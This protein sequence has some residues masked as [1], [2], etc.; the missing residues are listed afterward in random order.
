MEML[1]RQEANLGRRIGERQVGHE[2]ETNAL[3]HRCRW[4]R[5]SRIASSITRTLSTMRDDRAN[6]F[7]WHAPRRKC[8]RDFVSGWTRSRTRRDVVAS[9][10]FIYSRNSTR[11]LRN[12]L[13]FKLPDVHYICFNR[14]IFFI[15]LKIY[16]L[17]YFL[18]P[19]SRVGTI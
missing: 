4:Q 7:T 1:R 17:Q 18:K 19:I 11:L 16:L 8:S 6:P 13:F 10:R 15:H 3:R 9:R 5:S 2:N 14:N 12:V